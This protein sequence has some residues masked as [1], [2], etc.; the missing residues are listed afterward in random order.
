MRGRKI[1]FVVADDASSLALR[2]S[3]LSYNGKIYDSF[4]KRILY[5][6]FIGINEEFIKVWEEI[7]VSG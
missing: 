3:Y 1:V 2:V 4:Y 5:E 7:I 6:I